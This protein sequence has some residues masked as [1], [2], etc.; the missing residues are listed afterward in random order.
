MLQCF[1]RGVTVLVISSSLYI[2][3]SFGSCV[4]CFSLSGNF[5]HS[6]ISGLVEARDYFSLLVLVE[7]CFLL[8]YMI[9]FGE[10]TMRYREEGAFFC[11][12]VKYSVDMY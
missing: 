5:S 7:S 8:N 10:G 2:L 6:E 3:A 12:R 1:E 9:N 11:F 4:L